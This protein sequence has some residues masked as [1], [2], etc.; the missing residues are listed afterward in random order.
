MAARAVH[1]KKQEVARIKTSLIF[2]FKKKKAPCTF[3]QCLTQKGGTLPEI[4][5]GLQGLKWKG[6]WQKD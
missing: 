1:Q 6:F 4:L 3:Q 5:L 2:K